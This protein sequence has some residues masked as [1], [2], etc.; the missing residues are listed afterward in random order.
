MLSYTLFF[1]N[2]LAPIEVNILPTSNVTDLS[3]VGMAWF[4]LLNAYVFLATR[5]YVKAE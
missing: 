4:S 3:E 2:T 5:G 1:I